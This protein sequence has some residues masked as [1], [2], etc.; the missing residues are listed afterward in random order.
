[1][2]LAEE[3]PTEE[4]IMA[5]LSRLCIHQVTLEGRCD[6]RQSIDCLARNGVTMTAVWKSRLDEIGTAAGAA[7]LR[8]A[9]VRA[10]SLC[11]GGLLTEPGAAARRAALDDNRRRLEQ[12]AEI[13]AETMVTITG[14]L[15]EGDRNL[16]AARARAMEGLAELLPV[17]RAAGVKIAFEPLHPMV[18]GYRS[19]VSSLREANDW[20]D[21]IGAGDEL[22]IAFDSY[23]LWWEAGLEAEIARAGRR[24][25]NF[26]CSD[27]LRDTRDIRLDRGMFGDGVIDNRAIL[28]WIDATGFAGPIEV[29]IF[30]AENWWKRDPDEVVATIK[31]RYAAHF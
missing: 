17:A 12:A 18:C 8:D 22:G 16:A 23:A 1:M 11:F 26:H 9:G 24:I 14:G 3:R 30:S 25:L 2:S 20:L 27:W 10:V 31:E 5:D 29:E 4:D 7:H 6:F 19:V 13:G 28:A 15:P 21:E